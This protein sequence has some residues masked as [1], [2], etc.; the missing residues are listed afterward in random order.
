MIEKAIQIQMICTRIFNNQRVE[1]LYNSY[2]NDDNLDL[3]DI[4]HEIIELIRF[5]VSFLIL[6]HY[7]KMEGDFRY[8]EREAKLD[9]LIDS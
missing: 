3:E 4:P 2:L 1:E 8:Y 9:R 6:K 7:E 5:E